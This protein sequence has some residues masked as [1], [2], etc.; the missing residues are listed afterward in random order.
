MHFKVLWY[1]LLQLQ[2]RFRRTGLSLLQTVRHRHPCSA[3]SLPAI[4]R[5]LC[6]MLSQQYSCL[7]H[8]L[9]RW[10]SGSCQPDLFVPG[11]SGFKIRPSL[12]QTVRGRCFHGR[13]YLRPQSGLDRLRWQLHRFNRRQDARQK[14][15]NRRNDRTTA[16]GIAVVPADVNPR[17]R[18]QI[19]VKRPRNAV[20]LKIQVSPR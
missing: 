1:R 3:N 11:G 15:R 10:C 17:F 13:Q 8:R 12:R 18:S 7:F 20:A 5:P 2:Q 19:A 6:K 16:V 4:R 14:R 9:R